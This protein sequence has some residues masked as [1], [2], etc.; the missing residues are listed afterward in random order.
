MSGPVTRTLRSGCKINLFL[1]LTGTRP[2]G[3]HTLKTLFLPLA[4]PHDELRVMEL[5]GAEGLS[6]TCSL[7]DLDPQG[8]T[9][10]KAYRLYAQATGFAPGLRVHLEKGVPHGAGL[11]GG[12]ADAAC[13]LR[14]L[15]ERAL[16]E[17]R[18]AL[19]QDKMMALA[20]RVGADVPFFLQAV[21]ALA[22]GI[23][24]ALTPVPHPLPGFGLVL[25]CPPVHVSTAWA[26]GEWDRREEHNFFTNTL[27]FA[28]WEDRKPL[29]HGFW[30]ENDF[31]RVIFRAYPELE[32]LKERFLTLGADAAL[33]SGSGSSVFG[34]FSK[35]E[36]A[37]AA[38]GLLAGAGRVFCQVL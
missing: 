33:M 9:V 36:R 18:P 26:F 24:E 11:G 7:P 20:A 31:E 5:P 21:P 12:S 28:G 38:A 10:A 23:G 27:T 32:R 19:S 35:P 29:V 2:D 37:Q 13:L 34:L 14:Y 8:N 16:A 22:T 17:K 30:L 3:Y 4:E 25:V 15:N 6:L 1:R